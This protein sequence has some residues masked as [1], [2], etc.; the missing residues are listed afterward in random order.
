MKAR[1][2]LKVI[3]MLACAMALN[4]ALAQDVDDRPLTGKDSAGSAKSALGEIDPASVG[5]LEVPDDAAGAGRRRRTADA[6]RQ[7]P[8]AAQ[9]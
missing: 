1:T 9:Y 2:G 6:G 4:R 3:V 8:A 7:I 5:H